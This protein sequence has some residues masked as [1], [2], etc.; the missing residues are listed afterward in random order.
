MAQTNRSK[1]DF[2]SF[3]LTIFLIIQIVFIFALVGAFGAVLQ[4]MQWSMELCSTADGRWTVVTSGFSFFDI[5]KYGRNA[6]AEN[7][8]KGFI[9]QHDDTNYFWRWEDERNGG[10]YRL[11][12]LTVDCASVNGVIAIYT[13]LILFMIASNIAG[14]FI[15]HGQD[16]NLVARIIFII[17]TAISLILSICLVA[18]YGKYGKNPDGSNCTITP[19]IGALCIIIN[20]ILVAMAIFLLIPKRTKETSSYR[21][22]PGSSPGPTSQDG[23]QLTK[24]KSSGPKGPETSSSS[25]SDAVQAAPQ[26]SNEPPAADTKATVAAPEFQYTKVSRM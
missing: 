8:E 11:Y 14:W 17:L 3:L 13:L 7:L 18:I 19:I 9:K 12:T 24:V 20:A 22:T 10:G 26:A 25:S 21:V 5:I 1:I 23:I 2:R 4:R 15:V 16:S 6:P